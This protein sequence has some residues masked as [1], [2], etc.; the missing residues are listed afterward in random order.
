MSFGK[1]LARVATGAEM[2]AYKPN[3]PNPMV[4]F[5]KWIH[6]KPISKVSKQFDGELFGC[7]AE[8]LRG[9]DLDLNDLNDVDNVETVYDVMKDKLVI[10]TP[11]KNVQQGTP[12]CRDQIAVTVTEDIMDAEDTYYPVPCLDL[13]KLKISGFDVLEKYLVEKRRLNLKMSFSTEIEDTPKIILAY[14]KKNKNEMEVYVYG[15]IVSCEEHMDSWMICADRPESNRTEFNLREDWPHVVFDKFDNILFMPGTMVLKYLNAI[16]TDRG[17]IPC[18]YIEELDLDVDRYVYREDSKS[19]TFTSIANN[20]A[21]QALMDSGELKEPRDNNFLEKFHQEMREKGLLY[22]DSDI[23]NFDLSVRSAHLVILSGMSGTGKS[24]LVKTYARVADSVDKDGVG[25]HTIP[26]SP[27]WTDDSDLLGYIDY[28]SMEYR[29]ADT[30]L[31]S[32]LLEAAKLD[33]RNKRYIICFDEMNLARIEHYF[34]QFISIL[35]NPE[36]ERQLVLYDRTLAVDTGLKNYTKYPP[37]ININDNVVFVGTINIDDS[38]I[39]LSDKLLDRAH[40]IKLEMQPFTDMFRNMTGGIRPDELKFLNELQ[41]KLHEEHPKLGIGYRIVRQMN[42]YLKL[43]N[44]SRMRY[45]RQEAFDQLI[46]QRIIPK[47][48]GAEEQV[49][50]LIGK[51]DDEGELCDSIIEELLSQYAAL[52]NFEKVRNELKIKAKELKVY[53]YTI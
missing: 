19:E 26:V 28:K 39:M 25:L 31:V 45:S 52:S 44:A 51:L 24:Q 32:V 37:V 33:N 47:L 10:F 17:E 6:V 40:V 3:V 21:L 36:G 48:R 23:I 41:T 50:K 4:V 49:G 20:E 27:S 53:G 11:F 22:S 5:N 2:S 1:V 12:Q 43:L 42:D 29:P 9:V 30:G 18:D 38:T 14:R 16:R 34:S 8:F 13:D 46:V 15:S 7:Q 35:E